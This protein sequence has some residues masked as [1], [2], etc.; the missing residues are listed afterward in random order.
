VN[1]VLTF[2]DGTRLRL[3]DVAEPWTYLEIRVVGG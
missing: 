3:L 1:H 2:S